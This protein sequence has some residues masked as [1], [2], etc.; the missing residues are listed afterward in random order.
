MIPYAVA[1]GAGRNGGFTSRLD[2]IT[3]SAQ[4]TWRDYPKLADRVRA[5]VATDKPSQH[6]ASQ[7]L[8]V[9]LPTG[10][11]APATFLY[12]VR[13]ALMN[14]AAR[15]SGAL[16]YNGKRFLLRTNKESD[17][18]MGERLAERNLLSDSSRVMLLSAHIEDC[19]TGQ[20]TPFKVW[21]ESGREHLP[22]LRF[23]YQA[24]SFLRLSFEFDP[25]A[26]G[27]PLT[28]ALNKKENV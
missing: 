26:S 5:A 2:R 1:E 3:L 22:P 15:T 14:P 10:A 23:E 12:A 8:E 20:V 16:I 6:A 11:T 4:V 17:L 25:N 7:N 27:P 19:A 18:A 21:F 9:E 24:R 28:L 13:T